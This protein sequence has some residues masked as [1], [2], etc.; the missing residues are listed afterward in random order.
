MLSRRSIFGASAAAVAVA[1]MPMAV[2]ALPAP[3]SAGEANAYAERESA[4]INAIVARLNAGQYSEDVWDAWADRDARFHAWAESL[5]L[6]PEFARAKAIAFRTIYARNGGLDEFLDDSAT[7]DNR[8]ALQ[9]IKCILNGG[10][11]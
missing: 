10:L 9:V 2:A 7:T 4:A 8:L 11:N 5:P 3:L 6:A 1:A